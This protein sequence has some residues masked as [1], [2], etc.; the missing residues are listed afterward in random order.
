MVDATG[1]GPLVRFDFVARALAAVLGGPNICPV[2]VLRDADGLAFL[3]LFISLAG[4]GPVVLV[5][6]R[7]RRTALVLEFAFR[8]I[9]AV[10]YFSLG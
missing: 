4:C 10:P 8:K 9:D 2:R 6:I 3:R 1:A 7:Y 5:H